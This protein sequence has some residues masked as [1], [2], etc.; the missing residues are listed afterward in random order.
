[1]NAQFDLSFILCNLDIRLLNLF[2]ITSYSQSE[3]NGEG[4]KY[5][6]M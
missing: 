2:M 6:L 1:M 4:S 5:G 3:S